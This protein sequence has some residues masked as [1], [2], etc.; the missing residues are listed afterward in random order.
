MMSFNCKSITRLFP[1][2]EVH[3]WGGL[4]SQL[5][6]L[7]VA[8]RIRNVLG[9]RRIR[10]V[11][12]SSGVTKRNREISNHFLSD[13]EVS[14]INDYSDTLK[15]NSNSSSGKV[16]WV[17]KSFFKWFLKRTHLLV[18][19]N[20][21][22]EFSSLKHWTLQAR[23]H[24]SQICLKEEEVELVL[25]IFE[26]NLKPEFE[27]R[28]SLAI[29]FRLGDLMK[30]DNKAYISDQRI[31]KAMLP[32]PSETPLSIYSDSAAAEVVEVW[33][34]LARFVR[35]NI[36][37]FEP[38]ATVM[39]C[40][41]SKDFVGTSGKLSIWI[42]VLRLYLG[43]KGRTA[44]PESLRGGVKFVIRNLESRGKIDFY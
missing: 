5:Y 33:P 42:A 32:Y 13:F 26:F 38:F 27:T 30:L 12:H 4:G 43:Q 37:N 8:H 10:I 21:D 11:F 7:I 2:L 1:P 16:E 22:E 23:G 34:S 25:R 20:R 36:Y 29:H 17:G 3:T 31:Q 39:N 6:S 44:L 15:S 24:Y 35:V 19:L 40:V 9:T 41:Y 28:L 14:E 18:F